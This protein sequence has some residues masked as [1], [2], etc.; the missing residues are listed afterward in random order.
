MSAQ[1]RLPPF[2]KQ[3]A[4][5]RKLGYVPDLPVGY[6]L[7]CLGWSVHRAMT[8]EESLPRI[9]I[10]L[11]AEIDEYDLRPLAGLDLLLMYEPSHAHRIPE[12]IEA[13]LTIKPK[14]LCTDTIELDSFFTWCDP[15]FC[16]GEPTRKQ[17]YRDLHGQT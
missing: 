10:P 14:C 17:L 1:R 6:F 2:A 5:A 12:L 11:D 3:L 15:T 4:N 8:D 16:Y 7:I 13:L 9:V